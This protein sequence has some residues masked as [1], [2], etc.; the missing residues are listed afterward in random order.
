MWRGAGAKGG[1]GKERRC[2]AQYK[3]RMRC[4]AGLIEPLLALAEMALEN[5]EIEN[6][7]KYE[8]RLSR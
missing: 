2:H 4:D 7:L 5:L 1:T 6:A 8:G 3:K